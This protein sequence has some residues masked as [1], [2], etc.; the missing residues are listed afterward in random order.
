MT[1]QRGRGLNGKHMEL[2]SNLFLLSM[3]K[4]SIISEALK[5]RQ[6]RK[7]CLDYC[8]PSAAAGQKHLRLEFTLVK[9]G[10]PTAAT[11]KPKPSCS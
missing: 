5:G 10:C 11:V 7:C 9:S 2:M 6:R 3:Q 8:S 1:Q 4:T